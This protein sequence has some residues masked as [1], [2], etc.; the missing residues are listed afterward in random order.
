MKLIISAFRAEN[1]A[2]TNAMRTTELVRMVMSAGYTPELAI[3]HWKGERE[4]AVIVRGSDS[5]ASLVAC[6][7][8]WMRAFEQQCCYLEFDGAGS[9]VYNGHQPDGVVVKYAE[10]R[11]SLGRELTTLC[12]TWQGPMPDCYTETLDGRMIVAKEGL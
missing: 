8:R 3:G 11:K 4:I 10:L 6:G 9:V 7:Q 1:D 12:A 5:I 2:A